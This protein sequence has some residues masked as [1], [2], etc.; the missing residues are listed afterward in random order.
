MT[1]GRATSNRVFAW[2]EGQ[3]VWQRHDC[4]DEISTSRLP[5]PRW[6]AEGGFVTPSIHCLRCGAHEVVPISPRPETDDGDLAPGG[7]REDLAARG[8]L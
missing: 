7:S 4:R 3:S 6:H 8:I 1:D 5:F 2:L